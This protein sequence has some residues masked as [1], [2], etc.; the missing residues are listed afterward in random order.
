M[1]DRKRAVIH[2]A[3]LIIL[4]V[5][6]TFLADSLLVM[7]RA[8]DRGENMILALAGRT[9]VDYWRIVYA[10]PVSLRLTAYLQMRLGRREGSEGLLTP[11]RKIYGDSDWLTFEQ[12]K[13]SADL[14][15]GEMD[16][17]SGP[18]LGRFDR[19]GRRCVALSK[20]TL[21]NRNICVIGSAGSGKSWSFVRPAIFQ[22]VK[23]NESL[24]ITD[25]KGELY[26]STYSLLARQGYRIWVYDL[27]DPERSDA[28]NCTREIYD[29]RTG[30]ISDTKVIE[31]CDIVMKNT[32]EG[33][34]DG[35]WGVGEQNL[36]K[37][38][39]TCCALTRENVLKDIYRKEGARLAALI[40]TANRKQLSSALDP[41]DPDISMNERKNTLKALMELSGEERTD[42]LAEIEKLAPA[43]DLSSVLHMLTLPIAS[44][45]ARFR[46]MPSSSVAGIAWA[47][48]KNS[49]AN[50]KPGF[51]GGLSQRLQ[52]FMSRDIRRI[53]TNDDISFEAIGREKIA[54]F[55]VISDSSEGMKVLSSLFFTF[56]F[57]DLKEARDMEGPHN[58]RWVNVI[59]DEFANLGVIPEFDKVLSTARSRRI[60]I[61]IIL[62][63]IMQLNNRYKAAGPI[64]TSNCDTLIFL[65]GNDL[66]TTRYISELSGIQTVVSSS[67]SK[68]DNGSLLERSNR[69]VTEGNRKRYLI[70]AD[71]A[72]R[73]SLDEELVY[74]RGLVMAR[75]YR[76][77]YRKMSFARMDHPP[78]RLS[79]RPKARDK[80]SHTEHKDAFFSSDP[81][82]RTRM[83]RKR[84]R[85]RKET[86]GAVDMD[87][88]HRLMKDTAAAMAQKSLENKGKTGE[89][90]DDWRL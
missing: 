72:R 10:F 89:G 50:A 25:P 87:D 23:R 28:W 69:N 83:A 81:G 21:S 51:V 71:Q 4:W 5:V 35:F 20:N 73:L 90:A 46:R 36:F 2:M 15:T 84:E 67:V 70:N 19:R 61:S 9:F 32:G 34:E 42:R 88:V 52:L 62:Q 54:L 27:T 13:A 64:I 1:K 43:F 65:G 26:E 60:N 39:L 75:L 58:R 24:V 16:R 31:F 18:I 53:A 44:I 56:L 3:F 8:Y 55:C 48:F 33:K 12:A 41:T 63:S 74:H 11:R 78:S 45:E 82:F 30:N 59:C 80:Y 85:S 22:A 6:M 66:E 77:D 38:A 14:E 17:I 68:K 29:R 76:C 79:D 49:A 57:K 86:E 47:T 7:K 40:G 37:A